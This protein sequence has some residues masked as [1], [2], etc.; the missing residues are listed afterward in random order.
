M[1]ACCA[2]SSLAVVCHSNQLFFGL[3]LGGIPVGDGIL[4]TAQL[5]G[6][7][8]A[9]FSETAELPRQALALLLGQPG[10]RHR[11]VQR[12][13]LRRAGQDGCTWP[14]GCSAPPPRYGEVAGRAQ[15]PGG[16]GRRCGRPASGHRRRCGGRRAGRP[17]G[18][19]PG[20]VRRGGL[21]GGQFGAPLFAPGGC[22]GKLVKIGVDLPIRS[23]RCAAAGG[24]PDV[25]GPGGDVPAAQ[26]AVTPARRP[27]TAAVAAAGSSK[28]TQSSTAAIASRGAQRPGP[29]ATRPTAAC[30]PGDARAE[31]QL[32][33]GGEH[34]P[35]G[36]MT[37]LSRPE[38]SR[39]ASRPARSASVRW[40]AKS[41]QR[42]SGSPGRSAAS[43]GGSSGIG[44]CSAARSAR[45]AR[46]ASARSFS[47]FSARS[48]RACSALIEANAGRAA[49]SRH[50]VQA[51]QAGQ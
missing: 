22:L 39:A 50:L 8:A 21:P 40:S 9:T 15:L 37:A 45:S 35:S 18:V 36:W 34:E 43:Q 12:L 44:S 48:R 47:A 24:G 46:N 27:P 4:G 30:R 2:A 23:L 41:T 13:C 49:V 42:H 11:A 10:G 3:L 5:F 17:C 33:V 32:A 19:R 14:R 31:Q 51:G 29:G 25:P 26:R 1:A 28:P 16:R 38:A 7:P 6:V 20:P